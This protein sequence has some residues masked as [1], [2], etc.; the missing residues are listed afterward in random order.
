VPQLILY[1]FSF[2]IADAL[3]FL[4]KSNVVVGIVSPDIIQV[5]RPPNYSVKLTCFGI[6]SSLHFNE[7][8]RDMLPYL[9]PEAL[10]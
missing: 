8:H 1:R 5:T 9:P 4:E 2:Q 3:A 10:V 7:P 6:I